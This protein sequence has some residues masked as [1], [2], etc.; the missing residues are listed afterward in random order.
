MKGMTLLETVLVAGIGLII[1][2]FL[3]SILINHGGLFNQQNSIISGGLSSNDTVSKINELVRQASAVVDTY[4]GTTPV[5]TTGVDVL[6]LQL[7]AI[8]DSGV[9]SNTYDYVV[10]A[11]DASYSNVLRLQVFPDVQSTRPPRNEV[12][13]NL[14]KSIS[15]SYLNRNGD[16]VS[17]V[18][19]YQVGVNLAILSKTGSAGSEK[20]SSTVTILRNFSQ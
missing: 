8:N 10:V 12:L 15:F 17:P 5:Y 18:S 3:V 11:K 19:A 2:V 7:P 1:G 6:V 16:P 9:I 20:D 4:N 13:T 14:L